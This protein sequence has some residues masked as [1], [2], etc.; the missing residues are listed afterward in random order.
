MHGMKRK[1]DLLKQQKTTWSKAGRGK[2]PSQAPR[3]MSREAPHREALSNASGVSGRE[4]ET[5]SLPRSIL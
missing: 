2:G 1:E 4:E 5:R 3:V